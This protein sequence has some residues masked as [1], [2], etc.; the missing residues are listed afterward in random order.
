MDDVLPVNAGRGA[1]SRVLNASLHEL[2]R[3][4]DFGAVLAKLAE[5]EASKSV[6]GRSFAIAISA[7]ADAG[8][9]DRALRLLRAAAARGGR[10]APGVAACTAC[11]KALG[12]RDVGEAG[13]LLAA[14]GRAPCDSGA[15]GPLTEDARPNVRTLNTYLRACLRAG[16]PDAASRAL[17]AGAWRRVPRRG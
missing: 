16:A 2:A 1:R 9:P 11:V 10:C 4:R 14:M 7:C 12:G 13:A 6:D 5:G 8:E 3:R 15:F 17:E